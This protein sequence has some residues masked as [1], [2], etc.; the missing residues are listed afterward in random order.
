MTT[1]ERDHSSLPTTG[2]PAPVIGPDQQ[3]VNA[4]NV[5]AWAEQAA[6]AVRALRAL[7]GV[8]TV[9]VFLAVPIGFAVALGWRLNAVG[10]VHLFH[11]AGNAGQ[12]EAVWMLPIS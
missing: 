11:P 4:D 9:D 1:L 2:P 12:Y 5:N 3:A 6:E 7:P 10:G 8:E